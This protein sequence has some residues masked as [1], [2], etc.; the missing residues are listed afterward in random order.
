ME[1]QIID[2]V[3]VVRLLERVDA[4][5]ARDVETEI[6]QIITAGTRDLVCDCTGTRYISSAGLR[7]FLTAARALKKG[8]G[9]LQIVC[10]GTSY[11]HEVLETAGFIN[12]IPVHETIEAITRPS[13]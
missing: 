13:N 6:M 5:T 7:V 1:T 4:H 3:T 10:P 11:V 9:Q 2:N 8:G 12:I